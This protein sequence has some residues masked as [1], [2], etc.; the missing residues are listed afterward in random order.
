MLAT[1]TDSAVLAREVEAMKEGPGLKLSGR[2]ASMVSGEDWNLMAPDVWADRA[3]QV[4]G[5]TLTV[6]NQG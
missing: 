1:Y 3:H 6:G 2:S 5:G 4:L